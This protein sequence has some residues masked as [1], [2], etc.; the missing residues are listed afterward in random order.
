MSMFAERCKKAGKFIHRTVADVDGVMLLKVRPR[1]INYDEQYLLSDPY[2]NDMGDQGYIGSFLRGSREYGFGREDLIS[3]TTNGY[4]FVEAV[5][6]M[7]HVRYRHTGSLKDV[8][9]VSSVMNGGDGKSTFTTKDFVLERVKATG[10]TPRYGV[11][12]E[13]ISTREER[14]YW[15]AGSSLKVVDLQTNEVIAERVGYMVD[16]SQGSQAGGRS[17]WLLAANH[18]CPAFR[19]QHASSDQTRQTIRFVEEVLKPVGIQG[20]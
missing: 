19:G 13:D 10:P 9:R 8:V 11:T 5:D 14:D 3:T 2:G 15:I 6:P 12:Y 18:S 20:R 7:D 1:S 4:L 16:P 17:P